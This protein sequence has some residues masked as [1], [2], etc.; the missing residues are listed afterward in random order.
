[1]FNCTFV[2]A[3]VDVMFQRS[4][5]IAEPP[6]QPP[7]IETTLLVVEMACFCVCYWFTVE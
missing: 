5:F 4:A 1:M 6:F 2:W 3:G 7:H